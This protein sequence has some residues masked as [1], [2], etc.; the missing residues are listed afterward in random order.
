MR[1]ETRQARRRGHVLEIARVSRRIAAGAV[2]T[3]FPWPVV[4]VDID[5]TIVS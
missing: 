1:R 5:V 2:L 3:E 4:G